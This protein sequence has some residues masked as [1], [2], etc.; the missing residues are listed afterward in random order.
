MK[1]RDL[2]YE[3]KEIYKKMKRDKSIT[4]NTLEIYKSNYLQGTL[5]LLKNI[6]SKFEIETN[7]KN[8]HQL[9]KIL[10][11]NYVKDFSNSYKR[12]AESIKWLEGDIDLN[13][14]F[15]E[16]KKNIKYTLKA[17]SDMIKDYN[18]MLEVMNDVYGV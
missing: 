17:W 8:Q 12:V 13:K 2:Y 7:G 11:P 1:Y 6:A 16:I 9:I 5:D 15:K 14:S 10:V 4:E 3:N 18:Y